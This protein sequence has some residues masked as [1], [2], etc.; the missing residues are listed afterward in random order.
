MEVLPLSVVSFVNGNKKCFQL[1]KVDHTS[2]MGVRA[3]SIY[4]SIKI[5]F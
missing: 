5:K 3:I 1:F 2:L 4:T